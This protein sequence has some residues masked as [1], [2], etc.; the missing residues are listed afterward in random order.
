MRVAGERFIVGVDFAVVANR[1]IVG[2]GILLYFGG[3]GQGRGEGGHTV[4]GAKSIVMT[5]QRKKNKTYC[6]VSVQ[7]HLPFSN[8]RKR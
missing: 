8:V 7:N 4:K 3:G 1:L 2:H 5:Q 6:F